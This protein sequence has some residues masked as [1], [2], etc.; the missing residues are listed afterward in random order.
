LR[1]LLSIAPKIY[2]AS[3][4]AAGFAFANFNAASSHIRECVDPDGLCEIVKESSFHGFFDLTGHRIGADRNNRNIGF[5]A[6]AR[7]NSIQNTLPTPIALSAPIV[8]PPT[9]YM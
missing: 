8:L 2:A 1:L 7:S 4:V 5:G 3:D 6:M 9:Q